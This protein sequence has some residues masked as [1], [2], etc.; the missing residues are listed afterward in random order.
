MHPKHIIEL[1]IVIIPT[2]FISQLNKNTLVITEVP[3]G[4]T[5]SSLIDSILKANDKAKIIAV[6]RD[7]RVH[8]TVIRPLKKKYPNRIC[9]MNAKFR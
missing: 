5:T 1:K 3:F 8:E 4:T 2:G 6:D 7:P 9:A